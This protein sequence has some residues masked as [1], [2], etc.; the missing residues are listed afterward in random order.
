MQG[1]AGLFGPQV[2]IILM[3]IVNSQMC[4]VNSQMCVYV[5]F[6]CCR[7]IVVLLVHQVGQAHKAERGQ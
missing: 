2:Q 6:C 5:E 1:Q 3:C 4:V 7:E